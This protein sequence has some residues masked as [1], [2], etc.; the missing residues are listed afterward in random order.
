MGSFPIVVADFQLPAGERHR[1]KVDVFCRLTS[2]R[3]DAYDVNVSPDKRTIFL[4]S[5]GNMVSAL[6]VGWQTWLSMNIN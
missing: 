6:K 3:P 2:S 5:E 1:A 4:H